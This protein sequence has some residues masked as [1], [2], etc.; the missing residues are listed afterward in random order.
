MQDTIR[1]ALAMGADRGAHVLADAELQPLAVAKLLAALVRREQP[2]LVL[3]GKQA[4]DDDSNQTGAASRSA[5]MY[6]QSDGESAG[7]TARFGGRGRPDSPDWSGLGGVLVR[8]EEGHAASR[9]Q[10][11]CCFA[12]GMT[13]RSSLIMSAGADMHVAASNW[14]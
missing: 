2:S 1:T 9:V 8:V 13:A 3:L 10:K 4:I 12:V 11:V 7:R 6:G 5:T 14:L